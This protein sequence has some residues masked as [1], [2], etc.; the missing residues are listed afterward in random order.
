MQA[1]GALH[2]SLSNFLKIIRSIL[3]KYVILSFRA[4]KWLFK[5]IK[6]MPFS[7]ILFWRAK[8]IQLILTA[9]EHPTGW[10]LLSVF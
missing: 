2:I 6:C 3:R 10:L 8:L 5:T 7:E 1:L 9:G 4:I